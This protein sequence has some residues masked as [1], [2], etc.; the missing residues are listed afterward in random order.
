MCTGQ[1]GTLKSIGLHLSLPLHCR[2]A[3]RGRARIGRCAC[4]ECKTVVGTCHFDVFFLSADLQDGVQL[5]LGVRLRGDDQQAIQQIDGD[6][7]GRPADK[8]SQINLP[9]ST[10]QQRKYGR[11][12]TG[13]THASS[14]DSKR[15]S[16]RA[17]GLR[18]EKD[19]DCSQHA[20]CS[21]NEPNVSSMP[22]CN[23]NPLF[24]KA[25]NARLEIK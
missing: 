15:Q 11:K 21:D 23:L 8:Y 18:R 20:I 14:E 7:M 3:C 10:V 16:T 22:P 24:S 9:S 2:E 13:L 6:P 19:N 12:E 17:G 25:S 4:K 1:S 5:L